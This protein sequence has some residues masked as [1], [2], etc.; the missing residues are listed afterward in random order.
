MIRHPIIFL[1]VLFSL[2][3]YAQ[4]KKKT[5]DL[6]TENEF[7]DFNNIKGI[8]KKDGL[9]KE[10]EKKKQR[11]L[12]AKE[13][14]KKYTMGL[15]SLPSED[16][17]WRLYIEYWLIKNATILKWDF[18]K[19]DYGLQEYFNEF[20][21][22]IGEVGIKYDILYVNTPNI[23]HFGFPIATNRY[24]FLISVPF[25]R[26]LDLSKAEISLLLFENIIRIKSGQF[27]SFIP[28]DLKDKLSNK[29]FYQQE[30]PKSSIDKLMAIF[31]KVV[32]EKGFDFK[33]QYKTTKTMN[34]ILLS[35]QSDWQKYYTLIMK[36]DD[37]VKNN[38]MYKNYLR[39][40][41]SPELQLNWLNPK[42][43]K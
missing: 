14:K 21:R 31:D 13:K 35:N 4:D 1:I 3:A 26:T 22:R 20:L 32:L 9:E 24:L 2:N 7:V 38:L 37:L 18:Q 40:Y 12:Q 10:L 28:K 19:P 39:I 23:S 6:P 34:R 11:S 36:I 27:Q 41:P 17:F 29:S 16:D 43:K 25:I 30:F 8:L 33:Q 15:Y 42:N 5:E